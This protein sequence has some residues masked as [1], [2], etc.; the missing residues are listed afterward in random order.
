MSG[1]RRGHCGGTSAPVR[2]CSAAVNFA[3]SALLRDFTALE[4]GRAA[5]AERRTARG[6]RDRRAAAGDGAPAHRRL[7][8]AARPA[9]GLEGRGDRAPAAAVG[10]QPGMCGRGSLPGP[11]PA[12]AGRRR[13]APRRHGGPAAR[14]H[15]RRCLRGGARAS[16]PRSLRRRRA[17][18]LVA[19]AGRGRA[20]AA[21]RDREPARRRAPVRRA[22]VPGVWREP[23]RAVAAA[24]GRPVPRGTAAACLADRR[25]GRVA[26][27]DLR[28]A[29]SSALAVSARSSPA[30]E[31]RRPCCR[32]TR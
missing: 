31:T 25:I 13:C 27:G 9:D 2:R 1:P 29:T 15:P 6:P 14:L 30:S 24:P 16:R 28:R 26:G 3:G 10:D 18:V 20:T 19:A 11:S 22:R 8:R 7:G 17:R 23:G 5:E 21:R 12:R 4:A 32:S